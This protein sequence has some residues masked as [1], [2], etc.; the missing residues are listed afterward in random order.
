[1]GEDS[2][3]YRITQLEKANEK[4]TLATDKVK[5]NIIA[6]EKSNIRIEI[7]LKSILDTYN[8]IRNTAIGVLVINVLGVLWVVNK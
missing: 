8:V 1:M 4:L 2:E 3:D 5:D 6:I 7:D